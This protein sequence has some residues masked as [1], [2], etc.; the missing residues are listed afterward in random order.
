MTTQPLAINGT[1]L[2][3]LDHQLHT[4]EWLMR[5][6]RIIQW[7]WEVADP[8]LYLCMQLVKAQDTS[9]WL[10]QHHTHGPASTN[11]RSAKLASTMTSPF[12]LIDF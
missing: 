4:R 2:S 9:R 5:I 10:T 8:K 6:T 7:L 12:K 1:S 3:H 11:N